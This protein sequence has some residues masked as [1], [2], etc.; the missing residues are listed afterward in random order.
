MRIGSKEWSELIIDGARS[1]DIE[2]DYD[3]TEK[4]AIHARELIRWNKTFNLTAVTDPVEVALKHFLDS[5]AALH[6]IPPDAALLDI[7]SGGGFPGLPLKICMPTLSATLIDASRKK[8]NFLKHVIRTL[9]LNNVAARHIRAEDLAADGL[10]A[11]RFDVIIS[12]AFSSLNQFL[13]LA[14]PLLAED[15]TV[16]A[17]KGEVDQDELES[18]RG[19]GTGKARINTKTDQ[20]AVHVERFRLPFID[21]ARSLILIR[22]T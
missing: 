3:Q 5:L 6:H 10:S 14:L 21:A 1:F 16:I 17:L 18:L 15:G 19:R 7:G 8:A 9:K 2:L 4:F 20:Y 22:I 11:H 13:K 12:R